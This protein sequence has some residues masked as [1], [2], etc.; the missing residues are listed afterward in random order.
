MYGAN[1]LCLGA[2]CTVDEVPEEQEKQENK[3]EE[4]K[5]EVSVYIYTVSLRRMVIMQFYRLMEKLVL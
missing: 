1:G 4:G 3:Q 5:N 2:S